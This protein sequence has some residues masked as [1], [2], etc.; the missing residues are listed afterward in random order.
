MR[1]ASSRLRSI[2][3]LEHVGRQ[4]I[5]NA[6]AAAAGLVLIGRA[7]AA[8][9]RADLFVSE[10]LLGRV[11][12]SPVIRH[13]QM[14]PARDLEPFG[15]HRDSLLLDL[16]DLFKKR[17]WVDDHAVAEHAG[18]VLV[19]DARR[20]KPQNKGLVADINAV[21]GIMAALISR[22]DIKTVRQ[23]IDDLSLSLIAPLGADNDNDHMFFSTLQAFHS[24]SRSRP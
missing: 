13:Y 22:H 9:R 20:Q 8:E 24:A 23:Q 6:N 14:R 18:L 5:R 11:I 12:E 4:R 16:I 3:S 15:R 17:L 19:N 21:P 7:D 2:R 1:F 10:P